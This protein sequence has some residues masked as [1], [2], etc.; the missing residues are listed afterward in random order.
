MKKFLLIGDWGQ[1]EGD[2]IP[3]FSPKWV[4]RFH[5]SEYDELLFTG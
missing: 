5:V 3:F 1:E 4:D 2:T